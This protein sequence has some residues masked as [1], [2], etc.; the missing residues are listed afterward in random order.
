L[1]LNLSIK[2]RKETQNLEI[3]FIH[4]G[5]EKDPKPN[6]HKDQ[7]SAKENKT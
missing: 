2:E 4:I 7:A 6:S 5:R 1:G 3:L